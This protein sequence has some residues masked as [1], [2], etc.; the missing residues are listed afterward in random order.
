MFFIASAASCASLVPGFALQNSTILSITPALI[1]TVIPLKISTI[2]CM[3]DTSRL[4]IVSAVFGKKPNCSKIR[5]SPVRILVNPTSSMAFI[6][7]R[8]SST[9]PTGKNPV[10]NTSFTPVNACVQLSLKT[11]PSVVFLSNIFLVLPHH[12]SSKTPLLSTK[13]LTDSLLLS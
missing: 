8:D 12:V 11:L 2:F 4:A 10:L 1:A 3:G 13:F 9:V 6:H 7:S 5:L